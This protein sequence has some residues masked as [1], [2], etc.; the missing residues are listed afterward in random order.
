MKYTEE[1]LTK[2]VEDGELSEEQGL[3]MLQTAPAQSPANSKNINRTFDLFQSGKISEDQFYTAVLRYIT[4]ILKSRAHDDVA[5]SNLEDAISASALKVWQSLPKFD[6][7]R[8]GFARFVSVIVS[9]EIS[10]LHPVPEHLPLEKAEQLTASTLSPEKKSLFRDWMSS[11]KPPDR[12]ILKMTMD[13]LTQ[14][15]ISQLLGISQPAVA[16]RLRRIREVIKPPF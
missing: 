8:G 3:R 10:D 1:A 9:S 5:F 6:P 11:F 15:E 16:K 14:S 7:N 12:D 2:A 4:T 13:G